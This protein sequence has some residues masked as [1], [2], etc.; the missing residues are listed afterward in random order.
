M[1]HSLNFENYPFGP[2]VV[3]VWNPV[4]EF[5]SGHVQFVSE[6]LT[7]QAIMDFYELEDRAISITTT[8]TKTTHKNVQK[9][10]SAEKIRTRLPLAFL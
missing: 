6:A 8:K 2:H 9:D 5:A 1:Q 10:L 3:W 7:K 4:L